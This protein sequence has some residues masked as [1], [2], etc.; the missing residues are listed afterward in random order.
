MRSGR[1]LGFSEADWFGEYW[2]LFPR[3]RKEKIYYSLNAILY[4][5]L[6]HQL[7]LTP[8]HPA[9]KMNLGFGKTSNYKLQV[10]NGGLLFGA[11]YNFTIRRQRACDHL[12]FDF[13]NAGDSSNSKFWDKVGP[14]TPPA[15]Q[16]SKVIA[17]SFLYQASAHRRQGIHHKTHE[18]IFS[19]RRASNCWLIFVSYGLLT[20]TLCTTLW[21]EPMMIIAT[22]DQ[23]KYEIS[24]GLWIN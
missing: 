11:K 13:I 24:E 5:V 10:A 8:Y 16:G 22:H 17:V 19:L 23:S 18:P 21:V 3:R 9:W 4:V 1:H 2:V 7:L 6:F 15:R 20:F 14:I 12:L